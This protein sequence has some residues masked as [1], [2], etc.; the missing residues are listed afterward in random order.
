VSQLIADVLSRGAAALVGLLLVAYT[1]ASLMR[2][3]VIPR[4]LRSS[5]S[6]AVS[7]T[8]IGVAIGISRLRRQ[9]RGRDSILAAVGP[10]I[11]LLQL[12]A[13]LVLYL[14]AY[15]LLIYGVSGQGLGE[16]F[17]QSGSS[18]LTLGFASDD[19]SKQTIIDFIAAATG[20]IVIALLIGFLPTIYSA[21]LEREVNLTLLDATGGAPAWGPE[22]L[23]R[24]AVAH[25]L[26]ALPPTYT[27]WGLWAARLRLTHVTYPVL[28][29]VRSSRASRHYITSL[30]AVLD[31]A[32]LQLSVNDTLPQREAYGLLLQGGQT[33]EVLFVFLF[34]RRG[35]RATQPF[36]GGFLGSSETAQRDARRLPTLSRYRVAAQMAANL[37]AAHE[38][39]RKMMHELAS[40]EERPLTITRAEFDEAVDMIKRAGFPVQRTLDDAWRQ[41]TVY[42]SRYEFAAQSIAHEL[43]AT[44]APWSGTRRVPT[45]TAWPTR[46][47]D[48]LP[49]AVPPDGAV[50]DV[51][52]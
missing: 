32:A 2:T 28:V 20:P 14:I 44:P 21:Y 9:Y 47:I 29:W 37:D 3:V 8:V 15:G 18:L 16:S 42:R 11:I 46:I 35:W 40:G 45:P 34:R 25:D 27:E 13:W 5:L 6:D 26:E 39:D 36:T 10:T 4:A 33:F 38:L 50:G 43:D 12:I 31:A 19:Q 30:L 23:A 51:A 17:R 48:L 22:I 7:K 52:P 41:F 1:T 24:C 49:S